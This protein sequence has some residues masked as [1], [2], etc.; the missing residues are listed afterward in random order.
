MKMKKFLTLSALLSFSYFLLAQAPDVPK[1]N[2]KITGIVRDSTNS[3]AVEF[4]NVALIN[5]T[6]NKPV[7]GAVADEKGKFSIVKIPHGNY[8]VEISFIGYNTKRVPVKISEK[9][10]DIELGFIM[11]SPSD[12]VL[13]EVVVQGQKNLIEEKVDR[14]VY[15]ALERTIEPATCPT[16]PPTI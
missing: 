10:G 3:Q 1:G 15:N 9:K 2:G 13:N 5:P 8:F 4:A 11:V 14:T 12:K 6:T 7:D 16:S